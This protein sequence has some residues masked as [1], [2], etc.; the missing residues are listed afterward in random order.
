MITII[1]WYDDE[2][3]FTCRV[4]DLIGPAATRLPVACQHE[5]LDG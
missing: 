3:G 2:W 5:D 4:A 1:A